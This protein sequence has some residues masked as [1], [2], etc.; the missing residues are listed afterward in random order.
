LAQ[1]L[2]ITLAACFLAR[3]GSEQPLCGLDLNMTRFASEEPR[4][5]FQ[6]KQNLSIP[7]EF[8]FGR[9]EL[10]RKTG[11]PC[12]L[13]LL[14]ELRSSNDFSLTTPHR[15]IERLEYHRGAFPMNHALHPGCDFPL[16]VEAKERVLIVGPANAIGRKI[17]SNL[18]QLLRAFDSG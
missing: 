4:A 10:R 15:E 2:A 16:H 11:V 18:C 5:I 9:P 12:F 1:S 8:F 6:P 7:A 3:L 17:R 13:I 14:A